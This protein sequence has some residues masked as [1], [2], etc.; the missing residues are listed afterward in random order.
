[1]IVC[2]PGENAPARGLAL[3]GADIGPRLSARPAHGR[4]GA[5]RINFSIKIAPG[6]FK[7]FRALLPAGRAYASLVIFARAGVS[8]PRWKFISALARNRAN[9]RGLASMRS[10]RPGRPG[11]PLPPRRLI[12][13]PARAFFP[14]LLFTETRG[15]ITTGSWASSP[16]PLFRRDG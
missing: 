3:T 7:H 14:P 11:V 12:F 1:M 13:V 9:A 2:I 15:A 5:A 4:R 10:R 16:R 6:D 8:A